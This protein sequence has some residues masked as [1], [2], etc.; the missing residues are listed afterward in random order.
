MPYRFFLIPIIA[1]LMAY[2]CYIFYNDKDPNGIILVGLVSVAVCIVVFQHQI[3][4]WFW[5]GKTQD[6]DQKEKDWIDVHLPYIFELSIGEKN[7]FYRELARICQL[8]EFIPMGN[9]KIHEEIKWMCLGPAI[10]LKIYRD[11]TLYHHYKR[12]VIYPHPFLSPEM[13]YIHI[14]ETYAEDGVLIFSAEQL[15]NC[16]LLHNEYFN[17]ALYEWCKLFVDAHSNKVNL[18]DLN[19][20]NLDESQLIKPSYETILQWMGQSK[21]DVKSLFV[22]LYLCNPT[23]ARIKFPELATQ[24]ESILT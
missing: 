17:P 3:N 16:H 23:S 8:H 11:T 9:F 1:I 7:E 22:Y 5:I 18:E 21:L 4:N 24:I 15:M 13:D 10:R 2:L 20:A 12:T 19:I 6:L 14:S